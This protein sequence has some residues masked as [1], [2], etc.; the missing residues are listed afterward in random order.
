M[1]LSGSPGASALP[2]QQ[3]L[4]ARAT[5]KRGGRG[6][7]APTGLPTPHGSGGAEREEAGD[8]WTVPKPA[9]PLSA[10]EANTRLPGS[11]RTVYAVPTTSFPASG[12]SPCPFQNLGKRLKH[13]PG[14]AKTALAL[15]ACVVGGL[16]SKAPLC[17]NEMAL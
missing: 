5:L 9:V 1:V 13:L 10:I 15:Y 3:R 6:T 16:A 2:S 12:L 7:R 8:S 17:Y 11:R 14:L 4:P